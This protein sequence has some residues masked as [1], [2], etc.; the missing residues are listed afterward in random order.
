M[1]LISSS[2]SSSR[3]STR[4][5]VTTCIHRCVPVHIDQFICSSS[6]TRLLGKLIRGVEMQ[7]VNVILP[8]S[9]WGQSFPVVSWRL[10]DRHRYSFALKHADSTQMV[11][12]VEKENFVLDFAIQLSDQIQLSLNKKKNEKRTFWSVIRI[13]TSYILALVTWLMKLY[14]EFYRHT[15]QNGVIFLLFEFPSTV[16]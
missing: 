2:S 9:W 12:P 13:Y 3:V 16:H 15:G 1:K 5:I 11:L 10:H 8:F 4:L 14:Y 7:L 6:I